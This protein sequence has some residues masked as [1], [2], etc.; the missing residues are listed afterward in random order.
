M[1]NFIAPD[2]FGQLNA[3]RG[4]FSD[5]LVLFNQVIS[6]FVLSFQFVDTCS[7]LVC[8]LA[9]QSFRSGRLIGEFLRLLLMTGHCDSK[10]W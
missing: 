9:E 6:L 5:T 4:I 2:Q 8:S 3:I 1:F 7:R 10:V